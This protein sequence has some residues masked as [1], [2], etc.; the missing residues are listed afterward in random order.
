MRGDSAAI[1]R[2]QRAPARYYQRPELVEDRF[3]AGLRALS[4]NGA[5][6]HLGK[7]GGGNY[8]GGLLGLYRSSGFEVNDL[9]FLREADRADVAAYGRW[10]RFTPQGIFRSWN[11]GWNAYSGWTTTNLERAFTGGNVN[12]SFQLTNLW[13]GHAGVERSQAALDVRGL[14]GGP[15]LRGDGGWSG[16]MGF[17]SD[18]RRS[19]RYGLQADWGV[20]D[21][22]G[23][24][25]VGLHPR[26]DVRASGRMTLGL[27]PS[28]SVSRDPAQYVTRTSDPATGEPGWLFARLDQT[29]AALT[30]RLNYT[31]TPDLTLQ[32]YAQPFVAAGRYDDFRVVSDP[33]ASRFDDR[34]TPV[35][36]RPAE[37]DFNVKQFRSNA[38]LRWEYRPG[39]TLFVVWSQ[40]REH[41]LPDG[42]FRLGRD[43]GR[44]FGLDDEFDVPATNVLM[45]K[46]NYWI[47]M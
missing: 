29:V 10:Y 11:L 8:R 1:L 25:R 42:S 16:W 30:G 2:L 15:A 41:F 7:I 43:F 31:F 26:L 45:V 46:F 33:R 4:G 39:S 23:G 9:G 21:A 32:L 34:F 6:L 5:S 28:Y 12:G 22:P 27:Y 36:G 24:R 35:D 38:V 13:N 17:G 44:L 47:D 40:G 14:R 3:D 19:V 20:Q 37:P 18:P